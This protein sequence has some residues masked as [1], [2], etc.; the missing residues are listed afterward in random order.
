MYYP[1]G[2][3]M[4]NSNNLNIGDHTC[5]FSG[6]Q[7]D[8][9]ISGTGNSLEF[10]ARS[11]DPRLGRWFAIDPLSW[12]YPSESPYVSMGL[13]PIAF[14]DEDGRDITIKTSINPTTGKTK[15]TLTLSGVVSFDHLSTTMSSKR[16]AD[17]VNK[18]NEQ[19]RTAYSRQ[20]F[21][22]EIETIS[23][24]RF[25]TDAEVTPSDHVVYITNLHTG[26]HKISVENAGGFVNE[27]GGKKAYFPRSGGFRSATH[28]I[29]HWLG[30][31]HPK[32][33]S[34]MSNYVNLKYKEVFEMFSRDNLMHW[35]GEEG[36][37]EGGGDNIDLNQVELI[38]LMYDFDY[39]NTGD[40]NFDIQND[41]K[42]SE[43][44]TN[45]MKAFSLDKLKGIM[46]FGKIFKSAAPV[47]EVYHSVRFL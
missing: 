39:L 37:V 8:D 19:I 13:N 40:N 1:F 25:A 24:L 2:S 21:G 43:K 26:M 46:N 30:L 18:L 6:M 7:K 36:T 42:K 47:R 23:N 14:S 29:G 45:Y 5:G 17:Y 44:N 15:M 12:K 34:R 4:P 32:S 31:M 28:E 33:Y 20:Y 11:N 10:G 3:V 16:K 22:G 27:I 35:P 9:E 41:M 38:Q